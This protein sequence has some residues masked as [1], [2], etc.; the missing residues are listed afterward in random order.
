MFV[1]SL[2][3]IN[4][5]NNKTS[6]NLVIFCHLKPFLC[7]L[8]TQIANVK[9]K[10]RRQNKVI[11]EGLSGEDFNLAVLGQFCADVIT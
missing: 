7:L 2:I 10:E 11:K 8:L 5:S 1:I 3:A 9:N 4:R 6:H